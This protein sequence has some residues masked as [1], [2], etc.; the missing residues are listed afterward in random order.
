MI[1]LSTHK[2][3]KDQINVLK[4]GLK[5]CPTPRSNIREL[6]KDLK[7]FERE[8]RP[9]EILKIKK[10]TED[11]LVK[12]YRIHIFSLKKKNNSKNTE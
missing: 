12:N 10:D 7:G 11:S 4:L 9:I 6:E 5:F 1:N 3:N 8:L 2:L